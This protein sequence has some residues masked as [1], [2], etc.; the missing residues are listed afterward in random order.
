MENSINIH[1]K[2]LAKAFIV[3]SIHLFIKNSHLISKYYDQVMCMVYCIF[4]FVFVPVIV[5]AGTYRWGGGGCTC[6]WA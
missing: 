5:C 6:E 2:V 1:Q 3:L 4:H